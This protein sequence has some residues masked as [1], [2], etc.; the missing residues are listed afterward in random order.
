MESR[1]FIKKYIDLYLNLHERNLPTINYQNIKI[2]WK[3]LYLTFQK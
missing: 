2:T 1:K 3:I